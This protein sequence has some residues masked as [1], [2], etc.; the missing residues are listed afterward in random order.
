MNLRETGH[1][2]VSWIWLG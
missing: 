1:D 2:S